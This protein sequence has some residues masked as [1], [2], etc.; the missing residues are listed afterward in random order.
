MT[1]KKFVDVSWYS[2][3]FFSDL[4]AI[5]RVI[6]DHRLAAKYLKQIKIFDLFPN[7]KIRFSGRP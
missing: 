3:S 4:L 2:S 6:T 7:T 5:P 1:E